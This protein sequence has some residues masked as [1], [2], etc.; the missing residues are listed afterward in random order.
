HP[1]RE[2]ENRD[3]PLDVHPPC[4]HD[5]LLMRD[6]E[7]VM[8]ALAKVHAAPLA[9]RATVTLAPTHR[10]NERAGGPGIPDHRLVAHRPRHHRAETDDRRDYGVGVTL[11]L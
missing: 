7:K 2:S 10:R 9:P 4:G 1:D 3:S 11:P 6:V 5:P 8:S